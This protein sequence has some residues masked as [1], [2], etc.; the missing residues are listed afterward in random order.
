M[1]KRSILT[2]FK[3][4]FTEGKRLM[5][6]VFGSSFE[7]IAVCLTIQSSKFGQLEIIYRISSNSNRTSTWKFVIVAAATIRGYGFR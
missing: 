2:I 1:A 4:N 3:E 6:D 5:Q 7:K